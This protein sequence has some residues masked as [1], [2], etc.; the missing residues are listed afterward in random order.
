MRSKAFLKTHTSHKR[1]L[2]PKKSK[3]IRFPFHRKYK[4][5]SSKLVSSY[6]KRRHFITIKRK[7]DD[8]TQSN[9]KDKAQGQGPNI[10]EL[11]DNMFLLH[12]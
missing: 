7:E 5:K 8:V 6:R 12:L 9:I 10:D 3:R 2:Y 1:R 4:K 11:I